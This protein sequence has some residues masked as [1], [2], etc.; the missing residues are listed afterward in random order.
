MDAERAYVREGYGTD[1]VEWADGDGYTL[2][3]KACGR[4]DI[5]A[6]RWLLQA[7]AAVDRKSRWANTPLHKAC[8][9]GKTECALALVAA[10]ADTECKNNRGETPLDLA[11]EY[12]HADTAIALL[13][14]R[15]ANWCVDNILMSIQAALSRENDDLRSVNARLENE[16]ATLKKKLERAHRLRKGTRPTRRSA[17]LLGRSNGTKKLQT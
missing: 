9:Y 12:K 14:H 3:H 16:C 7:G 8:W 4:G 6:V 2:L 15:K 17:R 11:V 13:K 1:D 5:G 10:G